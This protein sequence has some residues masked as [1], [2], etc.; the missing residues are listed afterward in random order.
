MGRGG[1]RVNSG[2]PPDPNALR[3]DR[4]E[5][6]AGWT[7]LP[8]EGRTGPVP[9]W[10]LGTHIGLA[11]AL[12]MKETDREML[13]VQIDAGVA[14]RGAVGKLAKL[15]QQIAEIRKRIEA[16]AELEGGLWESLW[17][18]P[19][20]V[21]WEQLRWTREVALYVRWQVQAELGDLEAGKEARQW[22]DRLGLNPTALLRNR[23]KIGT[24]STTGA[25]PSAPATPRRTTAR[26]RLK[27]V[28]GGKGGSSSRR[29][30]AEDDV[31]GA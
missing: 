17:Q 16:A 30:S 9:E 15:D 14:A 19:Q 4:K 3:R 23:W 18:T 2:P 24:A 10:P 5:D 22:S 11:T 8:V 13:A 6:K 28:E 29:A 26:A 20:A 25:R 31:G 21:A 27:V 7:I 1:A 12:E